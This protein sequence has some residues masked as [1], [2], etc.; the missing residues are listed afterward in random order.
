MGGNWVTWKSKKQTIE[1]RSSAK[2]GF[3]SMSHDVC[4]LLWLKIL[5]AELGFL[6][7]GSM[8]LYCDKKAAITMTHNPI[9]HNETK[10]VEVNW[11]VMTISSLGLFVHHLSRQKNH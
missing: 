8:N 6:I 5:L 3:R 2:A 4:E 10:H 7:Q 9:H 1:T 11:H